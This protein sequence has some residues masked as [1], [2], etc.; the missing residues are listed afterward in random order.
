[1][2]YA[3]IFNTDVFLWRNTFVPLTYLNNPIWS[4]QSLFERKFSFQKLTRFSF[5]NNVLDAKA[6]NKAGCLWRD[7]C[8]SLTQLNRTVETNR[9]YHHFE[10]PMLEEVIF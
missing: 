9:P 2:L 4:K 10:K 6:S 7:I 3:P 5:G 8:I 1:V